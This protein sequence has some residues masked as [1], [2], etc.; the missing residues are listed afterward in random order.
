MASGCAEA[1]GAGMPATTCAL[2]TACLRKWELALLRA[3]HAQNSRRPVKTL[4]AR[5]TAETDHLTPQEERVARLASA[6]ATNA[7][8]AAQLYLSTYTV[9]YHLR[10]VFRKLGVASRRQLFQPNPNPS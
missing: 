6:R 7:D 1:G 10:K 3:E 4:R 8:I 2:P 5:G 9:D